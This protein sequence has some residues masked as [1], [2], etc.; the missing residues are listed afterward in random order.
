MI[1]EFYGKGC[2]QG[3]VIVQHTLSQVNSYY[4]TVS[5]NYVID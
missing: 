1:F 2:E 4:T 3:N 5:C